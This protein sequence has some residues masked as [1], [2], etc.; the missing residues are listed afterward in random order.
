MMAIVNWNTL[1]FIF[2]FSVSSLN[3]IVF[4]LYPI[5]FPCSRLNFLV[6][7]QVKSGKS[8]SQKEKNTTFYAIATFCV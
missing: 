4:S 1:Y 3:N 7:L 5:I 2:I 8:S 6:A